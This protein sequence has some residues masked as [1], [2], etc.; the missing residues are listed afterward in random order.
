MNT[1]D[2]LAHE[3]VDVVP[4]LPDAPHSGMS[5]RRFFVMQLMGA[6]FPITAGIML[7]GWRAMLVMAGVIGSAVATM[8]VWRRIGV[9]GAQLRW[10][11]TLW[12]ATLLALTLPPHL[13]SRL[14]HA[15]AF[16]ES[17]LW[18]ILPAAGV[19]LVILT[20]LL[21]GVGSGRVHPVLM[22]YLLL[23]VCFQQVL[24]PHYILQ[25]DELMFGDVLDVAAADEPMAAAR[26]EP[27]VRAPIDPEHDAVFF[28]PASQQLTFFTSGSQNPDR[29]WLFLS[30]LLRDR[31]PPLEDLIIAGEPGPIGT[32]CALASLIGGLFLLYRGLIDYRVPLVI[33]ASA[34]VAMLVLPIPVYITES[35]PAWRWLAGREVTWPVALTF[36]NYELMAGPLTFTAFFLATSPAVR[37]MARR[38]RVIYAALIGLLC[39]V[40]QLYV[41]VAVGPYLALLV[42]S[43]LAPTLDKW[44]RPRPLV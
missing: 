12:L 21:G 15:L 40:F 23:F 44:F 33:F 7:Y 3:L 18:P 30:G 42:V 6:L 39:G 43:L 25:R 38:A 17:P 37:P 24:V 14:T 4:E 9:R 10:S 36:V 41:T 2:T 31:M 20:W 27:W 28:E 16:G 22:T 19:A 26:A 35:S 11:H 29:A 1:A 32:S 5:V 34:I 13:A 8:F